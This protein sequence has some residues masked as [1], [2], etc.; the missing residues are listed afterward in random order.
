M[1]KTFPGHYRPTEVEFS[2]LWNNC[3][4]VLDANVLLNLYRYSEKT[5]KELI[6]MLT[7][8]SERLWVPHQAALEYH[9]QRL[10]VIYHQREAY[11][12]IQ[13]GLDKA[14][15]QLESD[16]A[17]YRR[18]PLIDVQPLIEKIRF[19]FTNVKEELDKTEQKH[20]DLI[21]N[22]P[23]MD[24]ITTL[25]DGKVG[26]PYTSEKLEEIYKI[27]EKRYK[28]KVPPGYSDAKKEGIEKYGDLILWFQIIDKYKEVKKPII[29]VTDDGKEDWWYQFRGQRIGPQPQLVEEIVE[30]AKVSFYMYQ[31]DPF[32]E[33]MQKHLKRKIEPKAIEE[34]RDIR[35]QDE[36]T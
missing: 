1:R 32:M 10:N 6:D 35:Q 24:K 27:G 31:T 36:K 11:G 7:E 14:R 25:L 28:E 30:I 12:R 19:A 17:N 3:L 22:D 20:P 2:E 16:L 26:L 4:F 23:L 29:F 5:V 33:Y 18:H 9:R 15:R 21:Q 8:I 13:E 34:V